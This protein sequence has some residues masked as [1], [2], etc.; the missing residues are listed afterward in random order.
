MIK[1]ARPDAA[2]GLLLDPRGVVGSWRHAAWTGG[3]SR[4]RSTGWVAAVSADPR[5]H[6]GCL[7][8]GEH[9]RQIGL[10]LPRRLVA[11]GRILGQ[12]LEGHGVDVR[13]DH[14]VQLARRHRRLAY[15]LV[16]HAD[17]RVAD[18]RRPADQQLIEQAAGRVDVGTGVDGLAARL[19]RGEVLRGADHRRRLRHGG[20]GVGDRPGDAEVHHLDRARLGQHDVGRLD[21]A[22]D[23]AGL[24]AVAERV[25]YAL[26]Q[27]ERPLRQDLAAVAQ[28]VAQ[29]RA[30]DQLHHDVGDRGPGERIGLLAG[31]VDR[32]DRG[33]VEPGGRLRLAAKTGLEGGVDRQ[34]GAELLDRDRAAQPAVDRSTDLGHAT[35]TEQL[36]ELVAATDRR[37]VASHRRSFLSPEPLSAIA[38]RIAISSAGEIVSLQEPPPSPPWRSA[39]PA[40]RHRCRYAARRHPR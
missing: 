18:E 37:R 35:A 21:V 8:P 10:H 19:L 29:R 16:R 33:V 26:G 4:R 32:D 28:H 22:V 12:R 38:G 3:S 13:S 6:G 36:S 30:L 34:V 20:A 23:D 17:R 24:V 14:R 15:V 40:G 7:L 11:V 39:R 5:H 9:P 27:L 2:L 1:T 25:E 31:V